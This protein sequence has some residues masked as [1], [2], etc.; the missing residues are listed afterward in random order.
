MS[1]DMFEGPLDLLLML[2]KDQKVDLTK[3]SIL[4]LAEQ[5]LR[6]IAELRKL[7]LELAADYLV[8]AAWLAYLKS[9]LLLPEPEEEDGPTGEEL[10]AVLAFR[11]QKLEAMRDAAAKLMARDRLGRNVFA[12][13]APEGVRINTIS[14][15]ADNLYDL[16]KAYAER[17]QIQS[18]S[19]LHMRRLPVLTI[20]DA[21]EILERLI[22]RMDE[23]TSIGT[24][25]AEYMAEPG[26]RASVTAS[27]FTASLEMVREGHLEIRQDETFAPIY[28]RRASRSGPVSIGTGV[29]S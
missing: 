8:M 26:M 27:S 11:L 15:H 25:L 20:K 10:A 12:R 3:I 23:W 6:F 13:G 19:R 5:Y 7:R 9:K 14:E 24:Y 22:G 21:R 1:L 16:L 4:A 17:R 2:A 29:R 28:I 18:A